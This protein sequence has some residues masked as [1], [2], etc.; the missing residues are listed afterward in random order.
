MPAWWWFI[1]IPGI[2]K[3]LGPRRLLVRYILVI[4]V[5]PPVVCWYA[6]LVCQY[7]Q[8]WYASSMPGMPEEIIITVK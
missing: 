3:S 6:G 7:H 5:P 4:T 1:N 2:L 8:W